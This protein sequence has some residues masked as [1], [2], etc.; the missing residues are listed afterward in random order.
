[1]RLSFHQ[2]DWNYHKPF[3]IAR[4]GRAVEHVVIVELSALGH[5]GRAE[6]VP[7]VYLGDNLQTVLTRLRGLGP[8]LRDDLS[9][10][11]LIKIM[12]PGATRNGLDCALWDLHAKQLGRPVWE[13]IGLPKPKP[14]RTVFTLSVDDIAGM[15]AAAEEAAERYP[16]LKLKL[17]GQDDIDKVTAVKRAAPDAEILID[18]NEAW[19]H[20]RLVY[21]LDAMKDLGVLVVEQP[22]P[23]GNDEMLGQI[24]RPVPVCADESCR[25][26]QSLPKLKGR[27]DL[28]NIKLEKCGGLTSAKA[29]LDAA[30]AAGF[31]TMVGT[32]S[33]TSLAMAPGY[34]IGG[35]CEYV[36]L[37]GPLLLGADRKHGLKYEGGTVHPPKPAL[38]G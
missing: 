11:D 18:A 25:G 6:A 8:V 2:E 32:M 31:Q 23:K 12:P 17:D 36:D 30:H 29:L 38:W 22:L 20:D 27:Y 28:V 21:L 24:K 33:G 16:R 19:P 7:S 14:M 9:P 34:V 35:A 1:M 15:T 26:V 13:L 4:G 5:T 10:W 3:V 37:D